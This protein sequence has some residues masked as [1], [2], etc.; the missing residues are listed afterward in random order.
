MHAEKRLGPL[1]IIGVPRSGTKLLR[2]LLNQHPSIRIPDVETEFLPYWARR[3]NNFGSLGQRE[4]FDRFFRRCLELPFFMQLD[5]RGVEVDC[6]EWFRSCREYTPAGVFE[7][8]IRQV[9]AIPKDD[10]SLVWGDKSPSYLRHVPLLVESFP[11]ARIVHIIRDVR[12][13][14]LSMNRAWGKDVLRAAQRWQDDV[15]RARDDGRTFGDSYREIRYEDL[16]VAPRSVLQDL[17]AFIGIAFDDCMLGVSA[18]TENRGDTKGR[19]EVVAS[20]AGKYRTNM[21]PAVV[22][23]IER[24][25]CTTLKSL[26]YPCDYG[27]VPFRLPAW[28][29]HLL[30]LSD[31]LHLVKA[32]MAQRGLAGSLQFCFR[33]FKTSGNRVG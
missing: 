3:W 8:L 9:M 2:G 21:D 16:L 23:R 6:E 12:D 7:A 24:I 18:V 31:G 14:S 15:S 27:G 17:C 26:G 10:V 4:N 13:C 28:K 1:F 19:R 20:N 22:Q 30:Q 32:T 5:E 11:G 25:A 29:R 33:Y